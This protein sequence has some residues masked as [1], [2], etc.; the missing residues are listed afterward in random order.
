MRD[1]SPGAAERLSG[2]AAPAPHWGAACSRQDLWTAAL[3]FILQPSLL[4]PDHLPLLQ[5]TQGTLRCS[6]GSKS[7]SLEINA[8]RDGET[9]V[10]LGLYTLGQQVI[11]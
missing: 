9:A 1:Q 5:V 10:T 3:D 8:V 2:S 6:L 4:L 7:R 11:L